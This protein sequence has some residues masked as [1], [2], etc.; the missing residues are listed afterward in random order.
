VFGLRWNAAPSWL[1]TIL[2][3]A[4]RRST[5]NLIVLASLFA[6]RP[7]ATGAAIACPEWPVLYLQA[8]ARREPGPHMIGAM[9]AEG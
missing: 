1:G 9:M 5:W 3:H 7:L 2:P 6:G 4:L 8:A